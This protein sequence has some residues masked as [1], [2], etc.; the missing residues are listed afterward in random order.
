MPYSLWPYRLG[1][2][3]R[4]ATRRRRWPCAPESASSRRSGNC[5]LPE[6]VSAHRLQVSTS[7]RCLELLP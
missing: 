1:I 3:E 7:S 4:T 2:I 5:L 6:T